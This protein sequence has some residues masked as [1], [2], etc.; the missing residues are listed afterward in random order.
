MWSAVLIWL[1]AEREGNIH[2]PAF[3]ILTNVETIVI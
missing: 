1:K 2:H 3:D